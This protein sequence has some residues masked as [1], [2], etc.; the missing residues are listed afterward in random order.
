MRYFILLLC[1]LFV[2]CVGYDGTPRE[3]DAIEV[4]LVD[5]TYVI[6]NCSYDIT[7][8]VYDLKE[9]HFWLTVWKEPAVYTFKFNDIK[10]LT[11]I[12]DSVYAL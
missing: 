6:K 7:K 2:G 11:I 3:V 4:T 5:T 12:E 1:L 8:Y 9:N 10:K